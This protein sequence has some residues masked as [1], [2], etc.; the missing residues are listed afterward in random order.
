MSQGLVVAL[1]LLLCACTAVDRGL[2]DQ[3]DPRYHP[4]PSY[5]AGSG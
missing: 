4:Y 1:A 2:R 3:A 5:G